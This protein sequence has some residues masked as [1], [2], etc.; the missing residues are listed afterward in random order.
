MKSPR[1]THAET[2]V[3]AF[4][5]MPFLPFV[6]WWGIWN[7]IGY[8]LAG[9]KMPWLAIHLALPMILLTGWYFGRIF[10][11]S[12]GASFRDLGW[13]YLVLM[14]LLFMLTARLIAPFLFGNSPFTGLSPCAL[15]QAGSG[16]RLPQSRA[17]RVGDYPACERTGFKHLRHM[18]AVAFFGVPVR[19]H[20]TCS[21]D[22][23]LH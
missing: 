23:I 16:L 15:T 5:Y 1:Q 12:R 20:V 22:G 13:L 11:R 2:S 21:V 3:E 17:G 6:A 7:L 10:N 4:T 14:P 9:E 19:P 18:T 8:T